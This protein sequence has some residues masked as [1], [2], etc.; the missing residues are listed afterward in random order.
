MRLAADEAVEVLEAAAA[1]WPGVER[2]GRA[3]LPH[4]HFMA[5][6]ELRGGVAIQ[7]QRFREGRGSVR[8]HRAIA[9][10]AGRDLGDA[11]HADRVVVAAGEQRLARRRAQRGRVEAVVLQAARRQTFGVRRLAWAA[12]GARRAEARIVDQDDEDVGRALRRA[13]LLDRRIFRVRILRIVGDQAGSL[14]IGDRQM[15]SENLVRKAHTSTPFMM[16]STLGCD[17]LLVLS[18]SRGSCP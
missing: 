14:R 2:P 12:E 11:A 1:G 6:A 18:F 9:G 16:K 10:R 8:Q 3:G 15:V 17:C 7:L 4:R 13:Q 5:L